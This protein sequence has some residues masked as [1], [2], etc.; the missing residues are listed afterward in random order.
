MGLKVNLLDH[1]SLYHVIRILYAVLSVRTLIL[2]SNSKYSRG[3]DEYPNS[4]FAVR[5][6]YPC[7]PVTHLN[8]ELHSFSHIYIY[9]DG[10]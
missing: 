7:T 6:S 10:L 8:E 2:K 5:Q 9:V 4:I 1:T 3:C